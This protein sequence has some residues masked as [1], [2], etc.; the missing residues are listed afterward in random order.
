[1][2]MEWFG[3]EVWVT[4]SGAQRKIG[5]SGN[6]QVVAKSI[7]LST[8]SNMSWSWQQDIILSAA[9]IRTV[10]EVFR[11]R[12]LRTGS[13]NTA[14]TATWTTVWQQLSWL[15]ERHLECAELHDTVAASEVQAV[16]PS[17]AT[18]LFVCSHLR[19]YVRSGSVK[20][21]HA[22][23]CQQQLF[24]EFLYLEGENRRGGEFFGQSQS[25]WSV[26]A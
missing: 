3:P 24:K 23:L 19:V 14:Q 15:A 12:D 11:R 10:S 17:P 1:M 26:I 5:L 9:Q 6:P 8:P 21:L 16:G 20:T 4:L 7:S 13:L 2:G 22:E 18:I 25:S